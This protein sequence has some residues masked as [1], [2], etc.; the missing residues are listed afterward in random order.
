MLKISNQPWSIVLIIFLPWLIKICLVHW[1]DS[2]GKNH[3]I[4]L[5]KLV[6]LRDWTP[7]F[8]SVIEYETIIEI[9]ITT[10][11]PSFKYQGKR[12]NEGV[13]NSIQ[14]NIDPDSN[15]TKANKTIG[16]TITQS[17]SHNIEWPTPVEKLTKL[18]YTK[19]TLYITVRPKDKNIIKIKN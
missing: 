1:P 11:A 3:I 8:C 9:I 13:I 15:E 6:L 5:Y 16:P 7:Q 2:V 17:K 19:R 18:R 14:L 12:I 4:P 10:K